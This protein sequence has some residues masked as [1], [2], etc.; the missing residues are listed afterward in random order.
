[1]AHPVTKLSLYIVNYDSGY[2]LSVNFSQEFGAFPRIC[3]VL[4]DG[5]QICGVHVLGFAS[6]CEIMIVPE[7]PEL[8]QPQQGLWQ[9]YKLTD[10]F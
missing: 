3:L 10:I 9:R 7:L 4:R 8:N 1:M 6:M 5:V 2:S